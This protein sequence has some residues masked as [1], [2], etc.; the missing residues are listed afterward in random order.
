MKEKLTRFIETLFVNCAP[1]AEMQ[2]ARDEILRNSLERYD[3]AIAAGKSE[4]EAYNEAVAGIGDISDLLR[5]FTPGEQTTAAVCE[6]ARRRKSA[7]L[8]A[9]AVSLYILCVVPGIV[10]GFFGDSAAVLG[11]GL[12]FGMIAV[13]T[14]LII[15]RSVAL[16]KPEDSKS[17]KTGAE[18]S[19]EK[20][21]DNSIKKSIK[22]AVWGLT[23][24]LYF[25]ISFAT[26]AWYITWVIF[27]LSVAVDNILD[28]IFT[29]KSTHKE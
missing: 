27:I 20:S 21:E 3:D 8:L 1:S 12:M 13:A 26:G 4:S 5:Q 7:L 25:L 17:N 24:A 15:F 16:A 23:L 6:E 10:C 2:S 19:S 9:V 14:A 28:A 11:L 29:L 18:A 22:G